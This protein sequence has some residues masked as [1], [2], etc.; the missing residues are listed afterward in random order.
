MSQV[1]TDKIKSARFINP[2]ENSVIE[3]LYGEANELTAFHLEVNYSNKEFLDFIEEW[4]LEKIEKAA[5]EAAKERA[6]LKEAYNRKII[7]TH[8]L[9][10]TSVTCKEIINYIDDNNKN[11]TAVFD[12]KLVILEQSITI[13]DKS[14]KLRIRKAKTILDLLQIYNEIKDVQSN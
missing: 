13:K 3:L 9:Q 8:L 10:N 1:F 12:F 6:K 2:P 11:T 14:L 4:P 7:E 5:R